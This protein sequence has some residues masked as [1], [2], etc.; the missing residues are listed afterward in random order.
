MARYSDHGSVS[1]AACDTSVDLRRIDNNTFL[2]EVV[3]RMLLRD[4]QYKANGEGRREEVAM[5][6]SL[7]RD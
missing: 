1:L 4:T 3:A 2:G 5:A 6:M 7:D